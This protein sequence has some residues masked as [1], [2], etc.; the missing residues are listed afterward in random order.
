VMRRNVPGSDTLGPSALARPMVKKVPMIA[1][2]PVLTNKS[3]RSIEELSN[4]TSDRARI[5]TP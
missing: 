5:V 1:A 4:L 2:D 3:R